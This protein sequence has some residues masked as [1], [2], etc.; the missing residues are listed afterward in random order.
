ML[1]TV[2]DCLLYLQQEGLVLEQ[3]IEKIKY[4]PVAG[5]SFD[6]RTIKPGEVFVCK[7][8]AFHAEYLDRAIQAGAVC[9]LSETVWK[10]DFPYIRVS[11]I[12]LAMA[13]IAKWFYREDASSLKTIGI[14]GTKGKTTVASFLNSI[15]DDF[16]VAKCGLP[17][18][19]ISS[20]FVYDGTV[21]EDAKLTTPEAMDLWRHLANAGKHL[22]DY[23]VC[24]VSSQALKYHRT[25]GID[26]DAAVFLNIGE[27]HISDVEHKDFEDYFSSKLSIFQSAQI[28]VINSS[29]EYY[30]EIVSAAENAGCE[31]ISFGFLPS[32][33]L[34]CTGFVHL[35]NGTSFS[36]RWKNEASLLY[37]ITLSGSYNVEN[38]LAALAVAKV[39]GVPYCHAKRG[40]SSAVAKGRGVHLATNDKKIK[41]IVD[42]AHNKMSMNALFS[43]ANEAFPN[44]KMIAVF[45]APGQ[46]AK[47]RRADMGLVAGAF[48]DY[49]VITEDDPAAEA[50]EDICHEIAENVSKTGTPHEIVYQRDRAI[51]KA[52][53][54]LE[55]EGGVL[56]LCGK[57]AETSQ[58]RQNG[59]EFYEGDEFFAKKEIEYYDKNRILL[60]L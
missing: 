21:K 37:E 25:K 53:S 44:Q 23:A 5:L 7:G 28:A 16:H 17:T 11:D 60:S 20:I 1:F 9:Y 51:Q 56:L 50:L 57:G 10:E 48:C 19:L 45:G 43:Y 36:A 24:E 52:F 8:V 42:Y 6:N 14:T 41:V 40:L 32:D 29:S 46:K 22:L 47:N 2:S 38:A 4:N 18:A 26:F 15:L 27:D 33:T 49:V 58:K 13:A 30:Q 54:L 35:E 3:S 34:Y 31:V 39:F 55:E 59:S 12:R